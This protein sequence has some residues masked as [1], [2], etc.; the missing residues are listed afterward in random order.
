MPVSKQYSS[1]YPKNSL[2]CR[3]SCRRPVQS[4]AKVITEWNEDPHWRPSLCILARKKLRKGLVK[5][6]NSAG[7][8]GSPWRTPAPNSYGASGRPLNMREDRVHG[9]RTWSSDENFAH[10]QN[11]GE[12]YPVH[13]KQHCQ[14]SWQSPREQPPPD[15]SNRSII[16]PVLENKYG[17]SNVPTGNDPILVG[18]KKRAQDATETER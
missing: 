9:K 11:V 15:L 14:K 3:R 13:P 8:N 18:V 12:P 2:V 5:S 6:T 7:D 4:S 10:I 17:I 16:R 1:T